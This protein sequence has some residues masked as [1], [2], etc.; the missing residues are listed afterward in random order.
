MSGAPG[1]PLPNDPARVASGVV[2]LL[3]PKLEAEGGR[4]FVI[5]VAGESGSGKTVTTASLVRALREIDVRAGLIHQ[6]DYFHRPPR[7]N[8]EQR[9]RDLRHV[10]PHEVNLALLQSHVDAFRSGSDGVEGPAVDYPANRFV[11][12]RH[13]FSALDALIV[14]GTYVFR[15]G[16]VDAKVFLEATHEDTRE[17]RRIRNRDIDAPF[18]Q[19]VLEIEHEIIARSAGEADIVIDRDFAIRALR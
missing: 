9:E 15:L 4:R 13:D 1:D 16:G 11:T 6:D 17:R 10:G 8:H 3:R 18:I 5:L 12:Q 19:Q 7:A 14:E 2:A